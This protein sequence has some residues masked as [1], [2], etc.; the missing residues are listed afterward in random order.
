MRDPIEKEIVDLE[1]H[2][3]R[4]QREQPSDWILI[5]PQGRL[6]VG[7]IQRVTRILLLNHPYSKG[8]T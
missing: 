7:D 6:Y 4:L 8:L 2:I 5:D 1:D 3:K